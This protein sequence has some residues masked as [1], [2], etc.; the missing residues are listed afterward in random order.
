MMPPLFTVLRHGQSEGNIMENC[1]EAAAKL[2]DVPNNELRL[3]REGVQQAIYAGACLKEVFSSD[4]ICRDKW[5]KVGFVS[6]FVRAKETAGYLR[7]GIDWRTSP[8]LVERDWGHFERLSQEEQIRYKA[9]K[10][11]S[12]LYSTMPNGQSLAGLLTQNYL[13]FSML[14]REHSE[15]SVIATC[16]GERILTIRY[17]L[18]RMDDKKFGEIVRSKAKSDKV[19]N[20]QI[21]QYS[22]INPEDEDDVR[23]SYFWMRSFCPYDSR[24]KDLVWKPIIRKKF[25]D[26]DLIYFAESFPRYL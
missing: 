4:G 26:E 10:K 8:F 3:T 14:H 17:M 1:P 24:A 12:P 6:T 19:R 21:L 11:R 16:H 20:C 23:Q 9:G 15:H 18:E 5:P 7:L 13:F 25:S 2:A 22:R